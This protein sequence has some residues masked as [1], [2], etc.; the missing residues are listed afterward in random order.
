[1]KINKIVPFSCC[2]DGLTTLLST[3]SHYPNLTKN[4]SYV[5]CANTTSHQLKIEEQKFCS[6]GSWRNVELEKDKCEI[7]NVNEHANI[8]YWGNNP[9]HRPEL[10]CVSGDRHQFPLISDLYCVG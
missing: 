10:R 3:P 2:A 6:S 5:I 8:K 4:D 9:R 1:M 7:R